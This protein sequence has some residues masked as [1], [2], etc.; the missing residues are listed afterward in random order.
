MSNSIR[1]P[2]RSTNGPFI[3]H[4]ERVCRLIEMGAR[5]GVIEFNPASDLGKVRDTLIKE[6]GLAIHDGGSVSMIALNGTG[7]SGF[8][9]TLANYK[10]VWRIWQNG[11]P[12]EDQRRAVRWG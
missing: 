10:R 1:G 7:I 9:L 2:Q 6:I 12:T 3:M 4:L 5:F 11:I 8:G